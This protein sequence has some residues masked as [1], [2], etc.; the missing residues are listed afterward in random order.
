MYNTACS[1][2][3][4]KT[5]HCPDDLEVLKDSLIKLFLE[6]RLKNS[7]IILDDIGNNDVLTVF[8][9]KCKT[10]IT[11]QNKNIFYNKSGTIF[12]EVSLF[13]SKMI[14]IIT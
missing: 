8:D 4:K 3:E 9:L 1:V 14:V 13:F 11:T 7:L 6:N 12:V 10:V 2:L 5:S